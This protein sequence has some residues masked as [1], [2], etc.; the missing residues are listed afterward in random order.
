[1]AAPGVRLSREY[2]PALYARWGV[3]G[4]HA[5]GVHGAGVGVL[6][7]DSGI[8]SSNPDV[9][10]VI[11]LDF[12]NAGQHAAVSPHGQ[13]VA[14]LLA[15]PA[16]AWGTVGIAPAARVWL[17]N[18]EASDGEL[19]VSAV[20]R[21]LRYARDSAAVD[22]IS[23][24]IGTD[25]R[26]PQLQ[27]AV[28][29]CL[30]R[31]KLVFAAC[32]NDGGF[33]VNYPAYFR[34]VISV[35]ST[36]AAGA[37]SSFNTQND[38]VVVF[39]P[40]ENL[41]F[42]SLGDPTGQSLLSQSGTSFSTPFAAGAAALAL[43]ERRAD[44]P[45][46]A[47]TRAEMVQVL[48]GVFGLTCATHAYLRTDNPCITASTGNP[49]AATPILTLDTAAPADASAALLLAACVAIAALAICASA[50]SRHNHP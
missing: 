3:G 32:G 12:A 18:V 20:V 21:A 26:D 30:L 46:F 48:R 47:Y 1:M 49:L 7:I 39:A 45:G 33:G 6:V 19:L 41:L 24:S 38:A 43:S 28:T 15:A 13:Y 29:E 16:N 37:P 25:V 42:V 10:G 2:T 35:G 50:L 17:A 14:S 8:R 31:G 36:D 11:E 34:G 23:M 5:R 40:G 22:I 9:Q 4:Y 44:E 27:A